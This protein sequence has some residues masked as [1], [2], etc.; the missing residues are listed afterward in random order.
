[1]CLEEPIRHF[2]FQLGIL[3][4]LMGTL[5]GPWCEYLPMKTI[6]HWK[7]GLVLV[8]FFGFCLFVFQRITKMPL[9]CSDKQQRT[10]GKGGG[11]G[12]SPVRPWLKP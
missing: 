3:C 6:K 7:L 10:S 8:W 5:D 1:M 9:D 2:S 11:E 4:P 12:R